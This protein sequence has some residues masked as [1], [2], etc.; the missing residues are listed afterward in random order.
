MGCE[1]QEKARSGSTTK[2]LI[3]GTPSILRTH[4]PHRLCRGNTPHSRSQLQVWV[5]SF[6]AFWLPENTSG[7][8][9]THEQLHHHG[10]LGG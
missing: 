4:E 1:R 2:I 3:N 10:H 7:R 5:Q 9:L 6:L 8:N